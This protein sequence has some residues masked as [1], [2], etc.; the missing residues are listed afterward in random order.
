MVRQLGSFSK[1]ENMW[2]YRSSA[3]MNSMSVLVACILTLAC[4]VSSAFGVS[5]SISNVQATGSGCPRGVVDTNTGQTELSLRFDPSFTATVG[6]G[7]ALS[8]GKKNCQLSFTVSVPAGWKF[9]FSRFIYASTYSLAPSVQ[10]AYSTAYYFQGDFKTSTTSGTVA[11]PA[12][13][14][15]VSL[16]NEVASQSTI[17]SP[18]GRSTVVNVNSAVNVSSTGFYGSGSLQLNNLIL[19]ESSF[20]WARC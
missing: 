2:S 7:Q 5:Y 16:Y 10:A 9:A 13:E 15:L 17:W 11:A 18:C 4:C 12:K 8:S 6:P 3:S 1:L 14:S 19:P 20:A